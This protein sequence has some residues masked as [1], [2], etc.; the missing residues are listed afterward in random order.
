MSTSIHEYGRNI[1]ALLVVRYFS[2]LGSPSTSSTPS[3]SFP[4]VFLNSIDIWLLYL[5]P[6]L[7]TY[8]SRRVFWQSRH[9][10]KTSVTK[11]SD[12]SDWAETCEEPSF[13]SF[14]MV[15]FDTAIAM[16]RRRIVRWIGREETR[17]QRI[18]NTVGYPYALLH[19]HRHTSLFI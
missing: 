14:S 6:F 5:C 11:T 4:T 3:R 16:R 15:C 9:S 10:D 13:W 18:Y 19:S 2:K 1:R 12:W 8:L 7:R 17:Q